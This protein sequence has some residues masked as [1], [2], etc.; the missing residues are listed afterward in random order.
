MISSRAKSAVMH[1]GSHHRLIKLAMPFHYPLPV[2]RLAKCPT[3][4]STNRDA[5]NPPHVTRK[6][7]KER[8]CSALLAM[9][10]NDRSGRMIMDLVRRYCRR[11]PHCTAAKNRAAS[12]SSASSLQKSHPTITL[13][14]LQQ[15]ILRASN[16]NLKMRTA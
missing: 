5:F 10:Y 6:A 4:C 15:M 16:C 13:V 12:S 3:Q 7:P 1:N 11:A 8:K 14:W 9:I 2:P